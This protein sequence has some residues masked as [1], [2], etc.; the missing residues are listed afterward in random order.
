LAESF[1]EESLL[2]SLKMYSQFYPVLHVMHSSF[3]K[4]NATPDNSAAENENFRCRQNPDSTDIAD[5]YKTSNIS[6]AR[7]Q[8]YKI[9]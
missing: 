3:T 6:E 4:E 8:T 2:I 1:L 7:L 5:S 9:L